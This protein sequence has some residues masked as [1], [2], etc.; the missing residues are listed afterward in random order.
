MRA[1]VGGRHIPHISKYG[2]ALPPQKRN[3]TA[4]EKGLGRYLS[5][6]LVKAVFNGAEPT[7]HVR[8]TDGHFDCGSTDTTVVLSNESACRFTV[9]PTYLELVYS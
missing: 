6:K 3:D 5:A 8:Q 4:V 1:T 2:Y 9:I 7:V